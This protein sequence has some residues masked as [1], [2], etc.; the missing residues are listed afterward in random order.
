MN[1]YEDLTTEEFTKLPFAMRERILKRL[2]SL[3][4]AILEPGQYTAPS[5]HDYYGMGRL[6]PASW[7][8]CGQCGVM[9]ELPIHT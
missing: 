4:M 9:N 8:N 1:P 3:A 2:M 5:T 7:P 6:M